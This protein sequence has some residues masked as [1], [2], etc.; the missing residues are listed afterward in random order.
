MKRR[1]PK[2]D[3]VLHPPARLQACAIL[4]SADEVEFAMLRDALE[5]SDSVLSKHLRQLDQARYVDLRKAK[6]DGRVRTWVSFTRKGRE[7]FESHVNELQRLAGALA[8]ESEV[9]EDAH[10]SR[11]R[12]SPA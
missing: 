3:P 12:R 11:R 7:A 8:P 5:V 6:R 1:V 10:K 9:D 2:F 4:A